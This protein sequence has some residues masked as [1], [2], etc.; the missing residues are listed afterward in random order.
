MDQLHWLLA[1]GWHTLECDGEFF[2]EHNDPT[3]EPTDG[4]IEMLE[5]VVAETKYM[6][7]GLR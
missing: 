6:W 1:N 2:I 3:H 7:D 4:E 5:T